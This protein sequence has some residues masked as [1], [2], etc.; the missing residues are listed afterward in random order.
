MVAGKRNTPIVTNDSDHIVTE[1]AARIFADL[2]DPQT[3]NRLDNG[4]WKTPFWL[5][6]SDTGL[7]LAWVPEPLGGAG[8]T[9]AEGFAVLGVAGRFAVAVPLAETLLAGWLLTRAGVAAPNGSM[10][11][12]P[13]RPSDRI[14]LDEDG[15]LSGSAI[16]IPFA[17]EAQHIA[18]LAQGGEGVV[19]ALVAASDC[20][21]GE[22]QTLA[23]DPSN[24]VRFQRVKPLRYARAPF[25][26]DHTTLML[27]GSVSRSVQTAGA[28]ES[29]LSLSVSYANERI[30]FERPIGKFQAVQHNLARLA[31][32]T[33][34]ALAVSGSAASTIGQSDSFDEIGFFEGASAKIRCA[35]AATEGAAIAHQV[36]GA[37]GFTK[38][39]ILHRFTLRIL[40]WRD[41]FGSESYW[42]AELG[43]H[44]A[45]QGADEFWPMVASR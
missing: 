5:A 10:T 37:I 35:E 2:A 3:I 8:A 12:A 29:I 28:L 27:M 7:P 20:T 6:L 15:T 11:I 26:L 13:S 39:H 31:G 33:A 40:A 23:G 38:E 16:G 4:A 24:I 9:L 44:V 30:A 22:G 41:D 42:A 19:V 45:Q 25:G 43:R 14:I 18:V 1:S 17:S 36:F 32:E 34:A 21:I